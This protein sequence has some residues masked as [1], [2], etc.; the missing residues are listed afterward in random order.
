LYFNL[1]ILEEEIVSFGEFGKIEKDSGE[2]STLYYRG[3]RE[4]FNLCV[5][6]GEIHQF[7]RPKMRQYF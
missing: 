3:A 5:V 7:V 4:K 1:E 2:G 6:S